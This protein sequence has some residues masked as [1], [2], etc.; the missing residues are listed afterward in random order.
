V[1]TPWV[2]S[3]TQVYLLSPIVLSPIIWLPAEEAVAV[4]E[5]LVNQ[6]ERVVLL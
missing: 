5:D 1:V 3:T 2:V 6:E 4:E